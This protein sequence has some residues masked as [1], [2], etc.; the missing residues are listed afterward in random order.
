MRA[1]NRCPTIR[2]QL[3]VVERQTEMRALVTAA[4]PESFAL[5]EPSKN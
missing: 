2:T 3:G 5:V 1:I 4:F